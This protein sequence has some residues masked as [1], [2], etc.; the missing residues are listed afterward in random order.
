MQNK[1]NLIK[2]SFLGLTAA[3]FTLPLNAQITVGSL[4]PPKSTL[5]VVADPASTTAPGITAPRLTLTELNEK[6]DLYTKDQ[7]GTFVYITDASGRTIAGYSDEII[8]TGFAFWN[9]VNWVGD[10]AT[11]K[12]FAA[13]TAQ[14]QAFTFYEQGTE[15]VAPLV[16]EAG[17]SS[18]MTYQWYKI[19]GNNLH[20]RIAVPCTA[21]DGTG[22]NT[23]AFTPT[24]VEKGTTR[25]ANNC[26]FYKYYCIAKN[27]TG[28]SV[29]SNI[30]EVAVGCGAK[31]MNGEWVSFLCFNL[32][33]DLL[34]IAGQ[35]AAAI[36]HP[37]YDPSNG[38]YTY[39]PGEERLYGDLYQWGRIG[40]GH[41]KRTN[42]S[43]AYSADNPPTLE[44][45]NIITQNY[46]P[47]SQVSRQDL[48]YYGKFIT[49][50]T[51]WYPDYSS[52][53]AIIA[54]QLWRSGRYAPNDPCAKIKEDGLTYETW[55]PSAGDPTIANT[56]W[57][58]PAQDEWGSI[59]R[60]GIS[61]GS[62]SIAQANTW[63]L[64]DNGNHSITNGVRGYE[65]KPDGITT[66]LFLPATGLRSTDGRFYFGGGVGYYWSTT[67]S[68][69][70]AMGL[71]F[72]TN[73]VYPG[74]NVMRSLGFALRC[75]K[76]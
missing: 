17:G 40:D 22:F 27:Q 37:D 11:A 69:G 62:S 32:G 12:T 31:D 76:D 33:A 4:E 41:E 5:E 72:D 2:L 67:I 34:T 13:A 70:T 20:V 15:P 55:Y 65:I 14:P 43:V 50:I 75:I 24:S 68:E 56:G 58:I 49:G 60:G 42:P 10:C 30:A 25:N 38:F 6:K 9:G 23:A 57:R 61:P 51:N 26:G 7:T 39:V 54:D 3:F 74:Y 64:Y 16:L 45:G 63:S 73:S 52:D 47:N 1:K 59:Y 29:V 44:N 8:C 28:D 46:Y 36:N 48:T 53:N 35:K 18:A 71:A 66:T 19:T 21:S